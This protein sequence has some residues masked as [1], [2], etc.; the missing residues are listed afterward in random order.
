MVL[1]VDP[2]FLVGKVNRALI[3]L[4]LSDRWSLL[5][6]DSFRKPCLRESSN[7]TC[8]QVMQ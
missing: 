5:R 8:K 7:L 1:K 3:L 6:Q 2:T 4:P